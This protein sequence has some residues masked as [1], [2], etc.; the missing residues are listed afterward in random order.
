MIQDALWAKPLGSANGRRCRH[1]DRFIARLTDHQMTPM[2]KPPITAGST[3]QSKTRM[4][5][6]PAATAAVIATSNSRV[7]SGGLAL[8]ELAMLHRRSSVQP[9]S[10]VNTAVDC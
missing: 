10:V 9:Q 5:S 6:T 3:P 7:T 2:E 1:I 4:N 8:S